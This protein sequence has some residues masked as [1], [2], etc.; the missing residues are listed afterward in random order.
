[1]AESDSRV[2]RMTTAIPMPILDMAP[3]RAKPRQ[4]T[5]DDAGR[6][7]KFPALPE[8]RTFSISAIILD[9]IF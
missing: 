5:L 8:E 4:V 1:M 9:D 7:R 2:A 3:S 6:N